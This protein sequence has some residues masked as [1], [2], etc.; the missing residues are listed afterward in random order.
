MKKK[1]SR[2]RIWEAKRAYARG[3]ILLA[4]SEIA[5]MRSEIWLRHVKYAKGV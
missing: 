3:E 5:L 2:R 1:K 4:Q